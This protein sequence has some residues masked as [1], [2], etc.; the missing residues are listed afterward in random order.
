MRPD[1]I[2]PSAIGDQNNET[3]S[4]ESNLVVIGSNGAGKTRFG[5]WIEF[6]QPQGTMVHR[7]AAQT[8]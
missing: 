5:S 4:G 2:L 7:I 6:N 3:I 1:I 8:T